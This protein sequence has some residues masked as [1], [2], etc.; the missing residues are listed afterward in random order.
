M[1]VLLW[2]AQGFGSGRIPFAPGT[3][4]SG[5]GLLWLAGLL[6]LGSFGLF[7]TFAA[8]AVGFCV[9][10]SGHAERVLRQTDP[11][12]VVLDEIVA[13]P[14][15]FLAWIGLES[16]RSSHLPP[17]GFFF[18]GE[19]WPLTLGV[20]GAF[21]LFD[22]LKPRPVRQCQRLPGGW[23]VT[24]DDLCAAVYVNLLFLGGLGLKELLS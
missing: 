2:I 22:I 4:G 8:A 19:N 10:C 14:V 11:P 16:L 15:C 5:L 13:V 9:F 21:R 1:K 20:F 12:S 18:N 7:V 6:T 23:G 24:M 3:F 17:P